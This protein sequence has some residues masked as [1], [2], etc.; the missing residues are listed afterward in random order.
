MS[1][2]TS[3]ASRATSS[4]A[5]A[6]SRSLASSAAAGSPGQEWLGRDVCVIGASEEVDLRISGWLVPRVCA[7]IVRGFDGYS[8]QTVSPRGRITIN[9]RVVT[10]R[11]PLEDGD[12]VSVKG[13]ELLFSC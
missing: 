8:L 4:I 1:R 7:V 5:S 9:R 10:G 12:E 11:C 6:F 2:P 3:S 13:H